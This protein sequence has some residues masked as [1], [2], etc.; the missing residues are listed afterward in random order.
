MDEYSLQTPGSATL[1]KKT[2]FS[3]ESDQGSQRGPSNAE[4][5]LIQAGLIGPNAKVVGAF[6]AAPH[7][8]A[9]SD[10][11]IP[12]RETHSQRSGKP[13]MGGSNALV[14]HHYPGMST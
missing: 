6:T 14:P 5:A 2:P 3:P 9:S 8:Q 12:R 10:Y 4:R 13:P 11:G 7:R 1:S